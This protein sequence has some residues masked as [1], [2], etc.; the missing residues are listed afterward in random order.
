MFSLLIATPVI[1]SVGWVNRTRERKNK[2]RIRSKLIF[3]N[4]NII[5]TCWWMA[6]EFLCQQTWS[7]NAKE[8]RKIF[9]DLLFY[10]FVDKRDRERKNVCTCVCVCVCEG[11]RKEKRR[12]MHGAFDDVIV[13][14]TQVGDWLLPDC[15]SV[16]YLIDDSYYQHHTYYYRIDYVQG[17]HFTWSINSQKNAFIIDL[18]GQSPSAFNDS[19]R[20]KVIEYWISFSPPL[21]ISDVSQY[22]DSWVTVRLKLLQ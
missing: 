3:G 1:R 22:Y 17:I 19:S 8:Q 6:S 14:T 9:F 18:N 20:I 11:G 10:S 7:K 21:K 13:N 4:Y 16:V 15:S 12:E 5:V 2:R